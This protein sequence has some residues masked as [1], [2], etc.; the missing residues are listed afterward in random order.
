M[1]AVGGVGRILAQILGDA[2]ERRL[3]LCTIEGQFTAD[4]RLGI[5]VTEMQ[6]GVGHRGLGAA[7]IVAD[8][9]RHGAG[10]L[11][12]DL[13]PAAGINPGDTAA[14]RTDFR[15]INGWRLHEI[16]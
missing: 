3:R 2:G 1:D 15:D 10:T 6:I 16:A 11:R 7:L 5:D 14:A 12:T 13:N 4:E 9:T 8:W